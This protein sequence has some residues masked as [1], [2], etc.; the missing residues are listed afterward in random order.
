MIEIKVPGWV[1]YRFQH[2]VLDV[3][4]TIAK[5]GNLIQGVQELLAELRTRLTIHLITADTH[6]NQDS[7]DRLL[8]IT[9]VRIPVQNQAKTKRDY[10]EL[11]GAGTV[12]AA[13]NGANDASMLE[14]AALGIVIIGPEGSSIETLLKAKIAVSDIQT[15]L[16]LL[17]HPKRLIATLRR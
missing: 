17:L 6:G 9:S 10:V 5:D 3:N 11:L 12:V 4:G 7:V 8:G 1:T 15:A 16:D 14:G 2:L 13:G